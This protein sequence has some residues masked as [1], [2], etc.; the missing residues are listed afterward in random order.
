MK[1]KVVPKKVFTLD[2]VGSEEKSHQI[3]IVLRDVPGALAKAAKVLANA[4]INVKTSSTFYLAEYPNAGVWSSFVDV[5]RAKKSVD[6]IADELRRT[7]VVLEV[8][9]LEP[10]P[11]PFESLHFPIL[12]GNTRAIIMPIGMFWALWSGF[13]RILH[14]SGLAAVLYPAGKKT[15]EYAAMRLK[16]MFNIEGEELLKALEQCVQ[17]TGWGIVNV[18]HVNFKQATATITVKDCF[19]A[20]AWRRKPYPVCHWTRGYFAGFMGTVFAKPVEAVE[21]KCMERGRTLRIPN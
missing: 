19:E 12:H 3:C 15:G 13:F 6:E 21:V 9:T 1:V 7:G 4:N 17:A 16:E 5:S 18:Q 8:F 10:K 11:T 2:D 14:H 20:A